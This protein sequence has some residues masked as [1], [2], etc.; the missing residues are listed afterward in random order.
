MKYICK[1]SIFIFLVSVIADLY[2]NLS[3]VKLSKV[4]EV[5]AFQRLRCCKCS[6]QSGKQHFFANNVAV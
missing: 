3:S 6:T 2:C 4:K 5:S 1:T